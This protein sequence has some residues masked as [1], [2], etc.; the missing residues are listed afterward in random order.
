MKRLVTW[1]L[2]V[3][4]FAA[5]L[6][7]Q[8]PTGNLEAHI[9]DRNGN[10][11][12]DANAT[13]RNLQNGLTRSQPSESTGY[14]RFSLMP[15]G[16]YSITVHAPQFADFRQ[17]PIDIQIGQTARLEVRLEVIGVTQSITVTSDV[18]P[19]DTATNTLGKTISGREVID[20]PLNGR[21]FAQLGLLQTGVAPVASGVLTQG[22]SMRQGQ[23]YSVNGQ[24]PE[25]N[26]YLLDGAQNVNR[27]DGGFAL[28]VPV[29]SIAE[30]RILTHSAPAEYG[31]FTGSTT[32]VVTKGGSNDFHGTVY[33]FFRNDKLD[34]RNFFSARREPLKQNQFGGTLGGPIVKNRIFFFGYYEGYRNRQGV[35]QSGLVPTAAERAGDFSG[36][37]A[38]LR[39]LANGGAPIP[40]GIISPSLFNPVA[41]QIMNRFY[42]LGNISP[43]VYAATEVGKNNLDQAGGRLDF[44]ESEKSQSFLRYSFNTGYNQNPFSV[45]GSA[46]PGFPVRDDITGH[47]VAI[48]NTRLMSPA[49]TNSARVSFLR[50]AFNFDQRIKQPTPSEL[51]LGYESTSTAGAGTPFFNISG[52]SPVGGAITGPRITAQNTYEVE[53][54][55]SWVHNRHSIKFGGR[56]ERLQVNATYVI[57]PNAFYVYA[58][59]YPT[60]DAFANFL[61]GK[62]VTF[63]QGVGDFERGMRNW[64]TAAFAQDEWRVTDKLTLN[65]GL[66]WQI[67]NPNTEVRNRLTTFVPGRQSTVFPNAP[68]GILV[69]GDPGIPNGIADS[70]YKAFM[71]RVGLAYDPTGKGLW[72]IRAAYGIFYDPFSNGANLTTQAPI[73]SV[74][75][76]EF[77]QIT[78]TN[79]P[80]ENPYAN[81]PRPPQNSFLTPTTA[82]VLDR[83]ARPPYA[84]DWNLSIQ[85]SLRKNYLLE[86]RYVGTKGT[87][88]PRNTE[89]NPAVYG[90]GATAS[91]ADRRRLYA[92]CPA[93]PAPCR[94]AT[95][96]VLN[97]GTNSSYNSGQVSLSHR[98]SAGFSFNVSYWYSKSIDYLS[99]ATL[100]GASSQTLAGENDMAQNP[101]NLKAERGPSLFD[102]THR[103]VASGTWELPFFEKSRGVAGV[104]GHGW[105]MN[106]IV[107]T[108]SGTPFTV[109]DS[110][111][112]SLQASAPPITGY[113]A[114]RPDAVVNAGDAPHTLT[115]WISRSAYRRL[116]QVTEAGQ[117]GNLG[118]NTARGPGFVNVDL[119]ATKIFRLGE[120]STL[121]FRA[122]SFNVANHPNFAIP[123]ADIASASFGR[124]IQAGRPRLMQFG[125][126]LLF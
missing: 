121:Q 1:P 74:P 94:L 70:D 64:G 102:A 9:V 61:L 91:N 2:F 25:S 52:Y 73:S 114:S 116:N 101:F 60:S 45:R 4:L 123:V 14:L 105:Q 42:P 10:P 103:F 93:T 20:L 48:S 109:Y 31:G 112:V 113:Y 72:S 24:R 3:C 95:V 110:A 78:G 54:I 58:G 92:D 111:N 68:L 82:V 86:V 107:T 117:F 7:A 49:L 122:E 99:S 126:K 119:S 29:D 100:A 46:L 39:D 97:Y 33:E 44:N 96:A 27:V 71:P 76:G 13:V 104:L 40:G 17:E 65:L 5:A 118:R 75:W 35:T 57:A 32:S 18:S 6:P 83:G 80:F 23:A 38:P 16:K 66:R 84:Q 12:P 90:P 26:N 87:H 81:N 120:G 67:I 125:L 41:V 59:S 77:F 85:R 43:S 37:P 106:T 69:A 22:G 79:V 8:D 124:I 15:A 98:Y 11:V 21:N 108:N 47:S 89:A 50:Y 53:D 56:F 30:F 115:Q 55:L 88:L 51:G 19:V 63:Y 36:I 62:P 28:K 34:G